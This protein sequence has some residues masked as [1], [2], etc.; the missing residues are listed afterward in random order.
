M[1]NIQRRRKSV[2]YT[3]SGPIHL[4]VFRSEAVTSQYSRGRAVGE[5][6]FHTTSRYDVPL[7]LGEG[8]VS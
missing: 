8:L 7:L 3:A 2:T 1:G 5:C 4:D 6:S